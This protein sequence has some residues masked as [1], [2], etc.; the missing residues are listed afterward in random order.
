MD[1]LR[2]LLAAEKAALS[3]ANVG[4]T[5]SLLSNTVQS[6][7]GSVSSLNSSNLFRHLTKAFYSFLDRENI[8]ESSVQRSIDTVSKVLCL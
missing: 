1:T 7:N 4:N 2:R 6:N 8:K 5:G 3:S